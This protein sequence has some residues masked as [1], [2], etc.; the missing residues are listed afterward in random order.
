[1]TLSTLDA[2]SILAIDLGSV[3]TRA[4]LFDVVEG[5]YAFIAA[6][7][8]PSSIQAPHHDARVSVLSALAHLTELTGRSFV[9]DDEKIILPSDPTGAGC[10]QMVMTFSG[11]PDLRLAVA[12]LLSEVSLESAGHLIAT[13]PGRIIETI[14]LND[15]RRPEAQ[16]DALLKTGP[17]LIL[18]TGGTENGASRSVFKLAEL[19]VLACRV[20]PEDKRPEIFY[21]GNHALAKRIGEVLSRWTQVTVAPN[22]RPSIDVEDLSPAQSAYSDVLTRLKSRQVGGFQELAGLC[23]APALPTSHAIGRM[24]RFLSKIYDPDKGVLGVDV[25]AS[26]TTAAAGVGGNLALHVEPVGVGET[27]HSLLDDTPLSEVVHWLPMQVSESDVRDYFWQKSLYPGSVPATVEALAFEQAAAR[28]LLQRAMAKVNAR[29][30]GKEGVFE[31]IIASGAILA[32]LAT[33]GQA[34]LTLLDGVQPRGVTTIILDAHSLTPSLGAVAQINPVLP[35][36]VLESGAFLNLGTVISP[37]SSARA[38]SSIMR[39]RLETEAG[40]ETMLEIHQG[41]LNRLPLQPGQTATLHIEPLHGTIIEGGGRRGMQSFKI[42]GGLCGAVID[43]RGRPLKLPQEN[44][45]RYELFK[46]WQKTFA[47]V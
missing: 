28:V 4:A 34:L 42:T 43:A 6:A 38:G 37:V 30:P 2:E 39:M 11:G 45:Q 24:V 32:A 8:A 29:I 26:H 20:L 18:L 27:L 15:H 44:A 36:Q 33:P 46:K 21:A 40:A 1:M 31:P 3:H 35:V 10:D 5:H 14:G 9:S 13:A 12:G 23:S 17:D 41:T 22:L 25:G 16:L 7:T 47:S 19:L